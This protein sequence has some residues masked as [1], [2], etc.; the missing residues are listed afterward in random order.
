MRTVYIHDTLS[1]EKKEFKPVHE[2][3]VG[4]YVCGPTTYDYAHIGHARV[5]IMYDVFRRFLEYI[6][7]DVLMVSNITDIDDKII[8]KAN[9]RGID[10]IE[11]AHY[12]AREYL[13]DMDNLRVRR[14]NIIPKATRHMDEIIE[15]IK[16]IIANGYAYESKGDV[17]FSVSKFKEYGK[18]SHRRVEEMMAGARVE[19]NEKKREPL[20]F[21][22]WKGAKEGEPWWSSPWGPGRPGWHIE[23]S[24]MSMRYIGE[25]LDI[26]GGGADLI[27]PHHENEIAQSEAA[28]GKRFVN[29]WMHVGLVRFEKEKMSKS[30]GNVFLVRDLLKKYPPEAIRIMYLNAHYRKPYEFNEQNLSEALIL[31]EK[32]N[33]TYAHLRSVASEEPECEI[34]NEYEEKILNALADDFNTRE[35]M[36]HYLE[37]IAKARNMSGA[38]AAGA[39]QFMEKMDGIFD[40]LPHNSNAG[41]EE[42]LIDLVLEIRTKMR[43]EKRYDIADWLRDSLA[44]MGIKIEDTKDGVRWYRV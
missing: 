21:A 24:A 20:D 34:C 29:Y 37:F 38:E 28:T 8:N 26:H 35:A 12:Y 22:L 43:K 31:M 17:Y 14:A 3:R 32:I 36:S 18:L 1:G 4:M 19:V 15:L 9:E 16:K 30:I 33:A 6:D 44:E 13:K 23:C 10:P 27:F 39:L 40:I 41:L 42:R 11:M 25:T 7:Y 2:G 5:A